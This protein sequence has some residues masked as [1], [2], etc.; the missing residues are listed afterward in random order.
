[1]GC[2]MRV[3]NK[4]DPKTKKPLMSVKE[5]EERTLEAK[6]MLERVY[7]DKVIGYRAPNALVSGWMLDSLEKIGFKYDS[8]VCVNSLY[9][10]TDSSL[11]GVSSYPY[12]PKKN[13]LEIGEEKF[14]EFPWAYWNV[15]GFKFNFN[16][17]IPTSGGP[18]LRFLG[19]HAILKGLKQSLKRGHTVFYFHP[20]D[21]SNEKF[22]E[23]GKGR[24]LYWIVKG[25]V[26]EKRI[27]YI[28][29]NLKDVDKVCLKD[30]VG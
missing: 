11:E 5:F 4:I 23:V 18:M 17:K 27:R 15:S 12:Y 30:A 10:K 6:E 1:M 8:S 14:V 20:I 28:L 26:V 3:K 2:I 21:I 7:K 9:N 25:N 13:G 19:A 29:K 24:P 16:L 22:P